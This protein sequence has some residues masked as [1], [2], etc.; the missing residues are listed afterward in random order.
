MLTL[1]KHDPWDSHVG[2]IALGCFG[3]TEVTAYLRVQTFLTPNGWWI[4]TAKWSSS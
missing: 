3:G 1:T 2:L 4:M